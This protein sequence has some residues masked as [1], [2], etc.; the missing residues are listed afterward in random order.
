MCFS[1]NVFS[2]KYGES[3]GE[4]FKLTETLKV[5]ETKSVIL[6]N[7]LECCTTANKINEINEGDL[8]L[9]NN[10]NIEFFEDEETERMLSLLSKGTITLENNCCNIPHCLTAKKHTKQSES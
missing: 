4:Y 2:L 6:K 3:K 5:K 9:I 7:I 1:N 8:I 10:V